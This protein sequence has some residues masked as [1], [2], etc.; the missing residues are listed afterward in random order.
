[1]TQHCAE[2]DVLFVVARDDHDVTVGTAEHPRRHAAI[3]FGSPAHG[4]LS[5]YQVLAGVVGGRGDQGI[6]QRDIDVL[7][8]RP[9]HVASIQRGLDG[10]GRVLAR[11]DIGQAGAR[12]HRPSAGYVVRQAGDAHQA[13]HGLEDRVVARSRCIGPGLAEARQRAVNQARIHLAQAGVVQAIALEVADL[14]VFQQHIAARDQIPDQRLPLRRGDVAGDRLFVAVGTDVKG[15]L[16]GIAPLDILEEG[17]A[18]LAGIVTLARALDFDHLR[19]Q[20]GKHLRCPR[21]GEDAAHIEHT[22]ITERAFSHV[23]LLQAQRPTKRAGR[24]SMKDC[25]PSLA[26]SVLKRRRWVEA[27]RP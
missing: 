18:E 26:S 11:Q 1:M 19:P 25:T 12:F 5:G 8:R 22:D 4:H 14:V 3:A 16:A 2:A 21:T 15:R 24:F 23:Y 9:V 7:P 17:R 10:V 27:M 6:Q 20:I 13:A